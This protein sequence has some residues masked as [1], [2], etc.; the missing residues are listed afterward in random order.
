MASLLKTLSSRNGFA[1]YR[2]LSIIC[3]SY[4]HFDCTKLRPI[5]TECISHALAL[6]LK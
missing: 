6:V 4:F 3:E 1:D 5:L 2:K